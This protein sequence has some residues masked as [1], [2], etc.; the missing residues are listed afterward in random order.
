MKKL[1]LALLACWL[2]LPLAGQSVDSTGLNL[3][4]NGGLAGNASNALTVVAYRAT[5]APSAP[6][7]GQFWCDTSNTPCILRV[8]D[9]TAWGAVQSTSA[10]P[11]QTDLTSFPST[12][13]DGQVF[14]NKQPYGI[15]IYDS[16]AT[17]WVSTFVPL[18][19][20]ASNVVD[21][22]NNN[23]I[24]A[25]PAALTATASGTA[26]SLGAG[27]YSYKVTCANAV[28]GE[29]TPSSQ[30]ATVTPGSSKSTDLSN[31][32]ICGTGGTQ[33]RIYRT[34]SGFGTYG[35][36]YWV[37]TISDNSTTT[38]ND[39]LADSS[40]IYFAPDVNFSGPLTSIWT[41]RDSTSTPTR[42]GC[43]MTSRSTMAC[44]SHSANYVGSTSFAAPTSDPRLSAYLDVSKYMNTNYTIQFRIRKFGVAGDYTGYCCGPCAMAIRNTLSDSWPRVYWCA[45]GQNAA[46]SSDFTTSSH[47][48]TGFSQRTTIGGGGS[49]TISGLNP[50]PSVVGYPVYFRVVKRG[51]GFQAYISTNGLD[52]TSMSTQTGTT[53]TCVNANNWMAACSVDSNIWPITHFE[54]TPS[55][56]HHTSCAPA[57]AQF[58]VEW[59]QLSITVQ[60]LTLN[61]PS[62]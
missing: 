15:F 17:Q 21:T 19:P 30:S 59:D 5:S 27:T 41:V 4:T 28:G 10:L 9:G 53:A 16:T 20:S 45:S 29:T 7:V 12:P 58:W 61:A 50:W 32:P 60:P 18:F 33:R 62:F 48:S 57:T 3:K 2:A 54:I 35:P 44:M 23:T 55:Y 40:A 14:F 13:V 22:Y 56:F 47:W 51:F 49:N 39:G 25:A 24:I 8:Y 1:G 43:G 46:N 11:T 52:W 38:L 37:A 6:V 26:G 42:G 36:W 31:I 34:K